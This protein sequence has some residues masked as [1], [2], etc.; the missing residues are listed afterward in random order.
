MKIIVGTDQYKIPNNAPFAKAIIALARA[1]KSESEAATAPPPEKT[2]VKQL[3]PEL[4]ENHQRLLKE[5]AKWPL[6][7]GIPQSELEAVL[8]TD[9]Q[10]LRGI[11][12]G[13][14][15]ICDRLG[16][17]KPLRTIG[18]NASNRSYVMD[19]DVAGTIKN[20]E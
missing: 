2:W 19:P 6:A 13:L 10:G 16:C 5:V 3:W 14:A 15:R 1:Y 9:W 7:R 20:L 17:E 11:H 4:G 18:Y 12:N 8:G